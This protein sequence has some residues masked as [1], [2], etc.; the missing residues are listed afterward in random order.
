MEIAKYARSGDADAI[1]GI[2]AMD[3][4]YF[5]RIQYDIDIVIRNDDINWITIHDDGSILIKRAGCIIARYYSDEDKR[6]CEQHLRILDE[7]L[8]LMQQRIYVLSEQTEV[9][10][11]LRSF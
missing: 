9:N 1:C 4:K 11:M 7:I 6:P 3:A 2:L 8:M 5:V 10:R